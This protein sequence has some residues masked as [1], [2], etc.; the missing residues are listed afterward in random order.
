MTTP[1]GTYETV[2][3]ERAEPEVSG[4]LVFDL[5]ISKEYWLVVTEVGGNVMRNPCRTH[6]SYV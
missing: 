6:P 2:D 3:I 4:L 1:I 5:Q